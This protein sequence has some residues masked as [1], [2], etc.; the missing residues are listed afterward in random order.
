MTFFSIFQLGSL[1]LFAVMFLGRSALLRG[2]FGTKV[3]ASFSG[4]SAP[5]IALELSFGVGLLIWMVELIIGALHPGQ[6][7]FGSF[8]EVVLFESTAAGYAG[9]VLMVLAL[10]LFAAAL[11]AFGRSWRVGIDK[12]APGELVTHGVFALSRNPIFLAM[13]L[14][15]A[16]TFLLTGK[17]VFLIFA[18]VLWL[19]LHYQIRQEEAFLSE[20]YPERYGDYCARTGR[21]AM[22]DGLIAS[23]RA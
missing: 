21:Y 6:G 18:A 19:G 22:F 1:G 3:L 5:Q 15:V 20:L 10:A 17:L 13:D 14:Y 11:G 7:L 2:W 23:A 16:G 8:S 4:K 12:R 9:V